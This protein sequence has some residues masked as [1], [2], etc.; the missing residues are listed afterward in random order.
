MILGLALLALAPAAALALQPADAAKPAGAMAK[1]MANPEMKPADMKPDMKSAD[2]AG[3]PW[4]VDAVHSSVIFSVK[5]NDA[6][7]FYGRFKIVKGTFWV[8]DAA[9]EKSM[10]HATVDVDSIDTNN[11]PRDGHL[12]SAEYFAAK[13]NPTITFKST[14]WKKS[15]AKTYDVTGDLTMR[16]VTKSVVAK[17]ENTSTNPKSGGLEA[18]VTVK[19]VD[20]GV[21]AAGKGLGEDVNLIVS[22]EGTHGRGR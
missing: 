20:F 22:L 16:G 2:A 15:G 18:R 8:D 13:D 21:G 11:G 5:H 19:R 9:P 1:P 6:A 12:K 4:S 14:A 7:N 10:I 17:V 3:T